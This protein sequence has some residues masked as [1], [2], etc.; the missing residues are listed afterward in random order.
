MS[1]NLKRDCLKFA[2]RAKENG[3]LVDVH[4]MPGVMN[5]YMTTTIQSDEAQ[6]FLKS[7][8]LAFDT[9]VNGVQQTDSEDPDD[10][11]WMQT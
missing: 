2:E 7:E 11:I 10:M 1:D 4:I 3:R 6:E 5:S 9:I 8:K